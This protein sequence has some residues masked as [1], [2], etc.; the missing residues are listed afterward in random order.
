MNERYLLVARDKPALLTVM[1]RTL[2]GHAHLSFE[3]K[4]ARCNLGAIQGASE[5]ETE[6]LRRNTI[7]PRQDFVVLPLEAETI[8]LILAGVLPERRVVRDII[9]IQIEKEGRLAFASYDNFDP[10][11]IVAWPPISSNLLEELKG[12]S[13]LRSFEPST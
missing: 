5:D 13:V 10:D 6:V 2:A 4:L 12:N 11:C 7:F 9:H 3:G 8:S 1:M